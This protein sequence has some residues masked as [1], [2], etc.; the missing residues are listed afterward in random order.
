MAAVKKKDKSVKATT[1]TGAGGTTLVYARV[2]RLYGSYTQLKSDLIVDVVDW[3]Y[4]YMTP[5]E[6]G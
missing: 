2:F 1:M 6:S 4:P 5:A 3:L